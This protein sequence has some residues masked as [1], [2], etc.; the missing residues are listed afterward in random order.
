MPYTS[1]PSARVHPDPRAAAIASADRMHGSADSRARAT[2]ALHR[3]CPE[4]NAAINARCLRLDVQF[5]AF[6][7]E[8]HPGRVQ[9]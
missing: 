6:A 7:P 4:C 5:R 3:A 1:S 8:P 2:G 9:S